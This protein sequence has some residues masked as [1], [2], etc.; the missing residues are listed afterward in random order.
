MAPSVSNT[1]A[2]ARLQFSSSSSHS[3]FSSLGHGSSPFGVPSPS[4]SKVSQ[5]GLS[6]SHLFGIPSLSQSAAGS[7]RSH[8]GPPFPPPIEPSPSNAPGHSP[9]NKCRYSLVV[10][11]LF[12]N[13]FTSFHD[14]CTGTGVLSI[15]P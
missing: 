13:A 8:D 11:S 1:Q 2:E 14:N 3:S 4:Q 15:S 12:N 10:P 7:V 5:F 6:A 9:I